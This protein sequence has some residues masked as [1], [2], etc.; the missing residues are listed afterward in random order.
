MRAFK[1]RI[2]GTVRRDYG[3]WKA[4]KREEES[5]GLKEKGERQEEGTLV[6]RDLGKRARMY[7]HA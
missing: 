2:E 7:T 3:L 1:A 5:E 4:S 6:L